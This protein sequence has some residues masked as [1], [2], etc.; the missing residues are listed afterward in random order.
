MNSSA[1]SLNKPNH[2]FQIE[3][4][5]EEK[6]KIIPRSTSLD[7]TEDPLKNNLKHKGKLRQLQELKD[8]RG[9]MHMPKV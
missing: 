3:N 6:R 7:V 5:E 4:E 9:T 1:F 8:L 2:S